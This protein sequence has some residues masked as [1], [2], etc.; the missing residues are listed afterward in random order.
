MC[1]EKSQD[2]LTRPLFLIGVMEGTFQKISQD[3]S[4]RVSYFVFVMY[5]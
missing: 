5:R 4:E 3:N 1:L 2:K